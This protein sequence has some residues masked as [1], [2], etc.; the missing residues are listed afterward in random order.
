MREERV[1]KKIEKAKSKTKKDS[2]KLKKADRFYPNILTGLTFAEVESRKADNL[3]NIKPINRSKSYSRIFLENIF[4]FCNTVSLILVALLIIIGAWDYTI[5]SCI[6]FINMA[7]GI[8]Q[9]IKAKWT[10]EKLSL[11]VES[12]C[13]VLRDGRYSIISTKDLVLDDL[14]VLTTGIQVPVDGIIQSGSIEVDESILTGESFSVR[15]NNAE[16]VLA[17]SHIVGGKAIVRADRVGK[18][19]YIENVARVARRVVKPKSNIFHV[20]DSIIKSI[21]FLLVPLAVLLFISNRLIALNPVNE[22]VIQVSSAILGM[23]PIGMFLLTSTALAAS[24]L[25]LSRR[26][27]LAQDLYSIEMLAMV[28]TLLLDKTGTITDGKLE[29][30]DCLELNKSDTDIKD[31]ITTM[32]S[33]TE[34]K[35]T[36]ADAIKNH[37]SGGAILPVRDVLAFSSARKYS[38]VTLREGKSYA[39]GA[40]DCMINDNARL[41]EFSDT[42]S[43]SCRRTLLLAE[44]D[45]NI[46]EIDKCIIKPLY[47]FALEDRLREDVRDTLKWFSDNDVDIKIVS[48]DNPKTVSEIALKTGVKDAENYINCSELDDK[49]LE[50]AVEKT[51]VF[52]RV[53]PEQKSK[54]VNMLQKKG[55]IVGM[56][57]DGVNDVQ[58]LKEADCSISFASANEVA[59][60]ISRIIMLDSNFKT[61]PGVVGEGRRV[62][63][64]IEKVSALYIMKNIF[65]MFMTLMFA[66]IAFATREAAYPF[67]TKKMLLIELFV[68]GVPTFALAL[69]RNNRRVE[70]NFLRNIMKS[71]FP[72]GISLIIGVLLILIIN[73][74]NG[75]DRHYSASMAAIALTMAGFSALNIIALPLNKFRLTV[76]FGMLFVSILGIYLDGKV[77]NGTFLDIQLISLSDT[78]WILLST[79][80][81]TIINIALRKLVQIIDIKYGDKIKIPDF[82]KIFGKHRFQKDDN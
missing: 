74:V 39:L 53:A 6:I 21:T 71:C 58:A 33:A 5:S 19:C 64:N 29:L 60:N 72:A 35:N 79:A 63:S 47:A 23:L 48:G 10:V 70:G 4:N 30:V 8:S 22:T 43:L 56:I 73:K 77:F 16:F 3:T 80:L 38:A 17:G 81:A 15:K 45:G 36:T 11:V 51:T 67:D 61:L 31:I 12:T 24:V 7:I 27:T 62:I 9:E 41:N 59:R 13:E 66:I 34:D 54:I 69:Q 82:R 1:N 26:N 42:N 28:D 37:Y 44:I 52:G 76:V 18:D 55:R 49:Q 78:L 14:F 68:I 75:Y 50:E 40:P 25:R 57:G 20:L 65:V 2:H 32:M 46:R